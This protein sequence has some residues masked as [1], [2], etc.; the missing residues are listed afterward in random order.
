VQALPGVE[1]ITY[2]PAADQFILTYH[3]ER[4]P[5]PYIMKA[6]YQAG[7]QNGR[8]FLAEVVTSSR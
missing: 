8:E 6:I 3:A 4:L 5:L 2:D 1:A 7:Q